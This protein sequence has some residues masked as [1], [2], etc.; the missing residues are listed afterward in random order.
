MVASMKLFITLNDNLI[1]S[2]HFTEFSDLTGTYSYDSTNT[3]NRNFL[4][5]PSMSSST[6]NSVWLTVDTGIISYIVSDLTLKFYVQSNSTELYSW[7]FHDM[8]VLQRSCET[9]VTQVVMNLINNLGAAILFTL[10]IVIVLM[11]TL[12]VAVEI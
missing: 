7:G 1:Y 5:L 9:C 3:S 2:K 4:E 12:F 8:V 10:L 6:I 11:I